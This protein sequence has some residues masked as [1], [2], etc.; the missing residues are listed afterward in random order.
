MSED[1]LRIIMLMAIGVNC[2]CVSFLIAEHFDRW[3]AKRSGNYNSS[4]TRDIV[5]NVNN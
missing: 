1:T 2:S 4:E 5:K 3:R